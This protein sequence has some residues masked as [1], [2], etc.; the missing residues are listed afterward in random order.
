MKKIQKNT[1]FT[2]QTCSVERK[3]ILDSMRASFH[4][5]GI[6]LPEAQ[7][8]HIYMRVSEKLKKQIR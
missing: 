3:Y 2:S 4:I 6:L 5:E 8:Q 7:M 1:S